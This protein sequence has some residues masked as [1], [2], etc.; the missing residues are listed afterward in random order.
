VISFWRR[1]WKEPAL[2]LRLPKGFHESGAGPFEFQ[3]FKLCLRLAISDQQ[4]GG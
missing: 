3:A 2:S 4:E 1:P